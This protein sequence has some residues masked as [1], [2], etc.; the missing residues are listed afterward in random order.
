MCLSAGYHKVA[1]G[2]THVLNWVTLIQAGF[3]KS[4]YHRER[5]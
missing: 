2:S 5:R 3:E 4:C 1:D